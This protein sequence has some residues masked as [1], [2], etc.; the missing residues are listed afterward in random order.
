MATGTRMLES[1]FPLLVKLA[2]MASIASILARSNSFKSMLMGDSRTLRQRAVLS[3]WLAAAFGASVAIRVFSESS[4]SQNYPAADLGL[5]GSLIA[6][7]L[8]GYVTGLCSG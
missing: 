3:L 6:G 8:G 7:I 2:A 1:Y 5:E 4:K